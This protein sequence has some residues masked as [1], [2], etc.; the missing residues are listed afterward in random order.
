M[1]EVTVQNGGQVLNL[2]DRK[3]NLIRRFHAI[4]LRDNSIDS[5][6]RSTQNGQKLITLE[7]IPKDL[8]IISAKVVGDKAEIFFGPERK[9]IDFEINWLLEQ[10]YDKKG[11]NFSKGWIDEKIILWDHK[12]ESNFPTSS[13]R[14]IISDDKEL[15]K[16]LE[17]VVRYGF[18]KLIEGPL[19]EGALFKLVDRFGFIRETNYGR[20]FEVK[21]KVNPSNLAFTGKG[22]QAHTDNPYRDPVPTLQILYCLEN[23]ASGGDN[24]VVDGFNAIEKL[25][26]ENSEWFDTLSNYC[27][28]FE[29]SGEKNVQL[30]SRRPMIEL[31]PD[32]ELISIRFNNRS[33]STITDVPFEKM[34]TYYDAYRRLGEIINDEAMEVKFRLDP[35]E[36]FIVDNT[37]VLHARKSY[38]SSGNRWL[39]G[40]YSDKDGLISRYQVLSKR[41]NE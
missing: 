9:S 34:K 4:W 10:S 19:E 28:K 3:E 21:N 23:S 24:M 25:Q 36:C 6:T 11:K 12:I 41:F 17:G 2:I 27:A 40:C 32:G 30:S 14:K 13:F 38:S 15:W 5:D 26:K 31:N 7:E 22:L 8:K 39:Q 1:Y 18:G 16:W 33:T 35:G 37:R 29:F 20:H